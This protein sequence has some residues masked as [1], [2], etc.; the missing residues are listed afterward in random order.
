[1]C[2]SLFVS[3]QY[4]DQSSFAEHVCHKPSLHCFVCLLGVIY[5]KTFHFLFK[6]VIIK[7]QSPVFNVGKD[8]TR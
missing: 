4:I 1:M 8:K 7:V 2:H 5:E 3:P 6:L